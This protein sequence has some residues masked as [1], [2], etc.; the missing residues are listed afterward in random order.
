MT[1]TLSRLTTGLC[2]FSL[3][4]YPAACGRKGHGSSLPLP[5]SIADFLSGQQL[6][7]IMQHNPSWVWSLPLFVFSPPAS[8]FFVSQ[9]T[10]FPED[11]CHGQS[12]L[13]RPRRVRFSDAHPF[14]PHDGPVCV[15]PYSLSCCMRPEGPW[16]QLAA[17]LIESRFS[18]WATTVFHH[19]A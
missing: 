2:V 18:Q 16:Q 1:P 12:H 10:Y 6:C 11:A 14:L 17:T 5:S 19:A 3:T 9:L 4:Y 13:A 8:Q 15:F 7:S